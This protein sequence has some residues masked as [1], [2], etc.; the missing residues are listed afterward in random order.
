MIVYG[1]DF[2]ETQQRA[3]GLSFFMYCTPPSRGLCADGLRLAAISYLGKL[4]PWSTR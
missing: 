3:S 2:G 4:D 1:A